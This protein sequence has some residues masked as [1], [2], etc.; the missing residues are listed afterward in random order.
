MDHK[1][2][3]KRKLVPGFSFLTAD[4]L[5]SAIALSFHDVRDKDFDQ[6]GFHDFAEDPRGE[7]YHKRTPKKRRVKT[8]SMLWT[9]T[10]RCPR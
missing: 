9:G 6:A 3:G 10:R 4:D 1:S 5:P 8:G 2:M 7:Y